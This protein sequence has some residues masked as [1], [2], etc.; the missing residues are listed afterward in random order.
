MQN[1]PGKYVSRYSRKKKHLLGHNNQKLKKWK[2]G[3]YPKGL[4]HGLV[5]NWHFFQLFLLDKLGH[6]NAVHDILQKKPPF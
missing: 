5:K 3:I 4:L 6:E 2:I 1:T